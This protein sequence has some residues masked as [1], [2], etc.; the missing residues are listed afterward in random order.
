MRCKLRNILSGTLIDK[1]FKAGEKFEIPDVSYR[2]AQ[3]LYDD[4]ES[5]HFMDNSSYEQFALS[6][7]SLGDMRPWFAEG[8]EVR[9]VSW[10]GNV[11]G[12]DLPQHV[13][14]AVDL[15]G[16]GSRSD[17]AGGKN[18]KDAT[19]VNGITIK[20]PLL[21]IRRPLKPHRR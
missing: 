16:G 2:Q 7:E 14:A 13:E 12:I 19:L 21:E 8:L 17:T 20:V 3:F 6:H 15:V 18:L 10:N 9:S 11:V 1:T 4:G 5:C